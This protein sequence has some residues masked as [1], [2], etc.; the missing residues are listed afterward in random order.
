M[1]PRLSLLGFALIL[2][3]L[4]AA[5][6]QRRAKIE[7]ENSLRPYQGCSVMYATDGELALGGNNEDYVNPLTRVW[8]IPGEDGALG[9]VY[10]GYD[11]YFAQGGMNERGLFFDGLG[12]D[13]TLAVSTQGKQRYAGNLVN[14]AMSE[15]GTVECVV[16]LFEQYYAQEAWSWQFLFG[17]ATGESVIIEPQAF[18]RQR[19][20]YQV[21][22]NFYQT[23]T[24]PEE[25]TCW[26]YQ[27]AVELLEN[28]DELSV[29]AI[30]DVL[31]AVH[32]DR[33]S[34]TLYSNVYDLQNQVVYL[35]YFHNYDEVVVLDLAEELE[36]GYHAYDLPS[37]FAPN[38]AAQ[39]W[40]SARLQGYNELLESRSVANLD[41]GVLQAYAGAYET[42]PEW[43]EPRRTLTMTAQE[44]SL[45][46]RFADYTQHEL[47]PAS[48]TDFFH[49]T[50]LEGEFT[51]TYQA[52]F[53]LDQERRVEYLELD[54]G[55]ETVRLER[56]DPGAS[57]PQAV[58]PTPTPSPTPSPS[59][60]MTMTMRPTA[61]PTL[62]PAPTF[63][64]APPTSTSTPT[65]TSSPTAIAVAETAIPVEPDEDAG[66]PWAWLI[67]LL[68]V[69]GAAAGWAIVRRAR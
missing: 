43:G 29:E 20:G 62:T 35:Y 25:I 49:V 5:G 57:V 18:I 4:V 14:R 47:F 10:F 22:T 9:G 23:L 61:T 1:K 21:A 36:Q 56:L 63:T 12:L 39:D 41:P 33:H 19:G 45:L 42:P 64:S 28:I 50:F 3:A 37:L 8:F 46:L 58:T 38:P 17:D 16:A 44:Q 34:P 68:V 53:G 11:D 6:G 13:E 52:S 7:V 60:T 30:R 15:C 2:S 54:L 69:V 31:D 27:T 66:F 55:Y 51:I 40:E 26:R 48:D 24:S 32:I 65:P 67:A 59:S